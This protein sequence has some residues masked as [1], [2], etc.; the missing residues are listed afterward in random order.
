M[1]QCVWHAARVTLNSQLAAR[2]T[3]HA[4]RNTQRIPKYAVWRP[5]CVGKAKSWFVP[6]LALA[7]L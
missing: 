6:P 1:L 3:Q 2:N 7:L 5:T 4:S